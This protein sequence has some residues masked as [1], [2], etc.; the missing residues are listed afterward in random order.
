MRQ[1]LFVLLL[2]GGAAVIQGLRVVD[3]EVPSTTEA[4]AVPVP[5]AAV[6][7]NGKAGEAAA[8]LPVQNGRGT[9]EQLS[10]GVLTEVQSEN[11]NG[12][13]AA[14]DA[15][16][17]EALMSA[18][19]EDW[20]M[21]S[22]GSLKKHIG[23][24]VQKVAK[25]FRE[26]GLDDTEYGLPGKNECPMGTVRI[27]KEDLCQEAADMLGLEYKGR[28]YD[29]RPHFPKG[30]FVFDVEPAKVYFN[31]HITGKC[32]SQSKLVCD[33]PTGK[34]SVQTFPNGTRRTCRRKALPK[35]NRL[36]AFKEPPGAENLPD[37][38][39]TIR[40]RCCSRCLSYTSGVG[41]RVTAIGGAG[42]PCDSGSGC[43]KWLV[44][45]VGEEL[46]TIQHACTQRFLV[47]FAEGD[48]A[49]KLAEDGQ[50]NNRA[51]RLTRV[52]PCV[53]PSTEC[54]YQIASPDDDRLLD[55]QDP[56]CVVGSSPSVSTAYGGDRGLNPDS[57][58][59]Y[60][61]LPGLA[62]RPGQPG[63]P[64]QPGW[65][66]LPGQSGQPGQPGQPGD[67]LL[68]G[69][70]AD[71]SPSAPFQPGD[72]NDPNLTGAGDGADND[73]ANNPVN[74]GPGGNRSNDT[75]DADDSDIAA[76]QSK[77]NDLRSNN[78]SW[79]P[80][81]RNHTDYRRHRVRC[82]PP[83]P[84]FDGPPIHCTGK[85][86]HNYEAAWEGCFSTAGC[87]KICKE[88]G[89]YILGYVDDHLREGADRW[90]DRDNDR[91]DREDRWWERNDRWRGHR[92][93]DYS[94]HYSYPVER[95]GHT[96]YGYHCLEDGNPESHCG[97][98][99]NKHYDWCWTDHEGKWDY[100]VRR[101]ETSRGWT[102]RGGHGYG[103]TCSPRNHKKYSWCWTNTG[104][105][106]YCVSDHWYHDDHGDDVCL[107]AAAF[108]QLTDDSAQYSLP[109]CDD[110]SKGDAEDLGDERDASFVSALEY[111]A[112]PTDVKRLMCCSQ[113]GKCCG[114]ATAAG[115]SAGVSAAAGL[116][117]A[118]SK[119]GM[120]SLLAED[121]DGN[122]SEEI[123]MPASSL[124]D[125]GRAV[126]SDLDEDMVLA[127]VGHS[128]QNASGGS[129][130]HIRAVTKGKRGIWDKVKS[131]GKAVVT[132]L[133]P[134][135]APTPRPTPLFATPAPTRVMPSQCAARDVEHQV[136]ARLPMDSEA[137][138]WILRPTTAP[139]EEDCGRC[140]FRA[141][142]TPAPTP[143]PTRGCP[144][145]HDK[146]MQDFDRRQMEPP[147]PPTTTTTTMTLCASE[148]NSIKKL[149][150]MA[151]HPPTPCPRPP[152]PRPLPRPQAPAAPP[153]AK[154]RLPSALKNAF[155]AAFK[156]L[157]TT[158]TTTEVNIDQEMAR[159]SAGATTTKSLISKLKD[160]SDAVVPDELK[161][162]EQDRDDARKAVKAAED[163]GNKQDLERAQA[164]EAASEAAVEKA[165]NLKD[166]VQ[167]QS[168]QDPDNKQ[169]ADLSDKMQD[170][171]P[172]SLESTTVPPDGEADEVSD[173]LKAAAEQLVQAQSSQA[174]DAEE[175]TSA[176]AETTQDSASAETALD[177]SSTSS[178]ADAM[179]DSNSASDVSTSDSPVSGDVLAEAAAAGLEDPSSSQAP[180]ESLA[181]A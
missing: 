47:P 97:Q 84:N 79:Q 50:E 19:N 99:R 92:S 62:G 166:A 63:Q 18:L 40:G 9:Q 28:A 155:K 68:S 158:K 106:D 100:C 93:M 148:F 142:P 55:A 164:W 112:S 120:N 159:L 152:P 27:E 171:V 38:F 45:K 132:A 49:L 135:A 33:K 91:W 156:K 60:G 136:R 48:Y 75:I 161:S 123:Q 145:D 5:T 149:L 172:D 96:S 125:I 139:F 6:A 26:P 8:Q 167:A 117:A 86:Y 73:T 95:T 147:L 134:T 98:H 121:A 25:M 81:R 16:S 89:E 115:L 129:I 39:Y 42:V 37:N 150:A 12:L 57:P 52:S 22:I 82:P 151:E 51:W 23:K 11:G 17:E 35:L 174:V 65:P 14:V 157:L 30:C 165:Q 54:G 94:C 78:S 32:Q 74:C 140:G 72:P 102:C 130:H 178:Q 128:R 41:S 176:P 108:T 118:A 107:H 179:L 1:C 76:L 7:P 111:V 44:K 3:D 116:S 160:L 21:P 181:A 103:G 163:S 61:N 10:S 34:V 119:L 43:Q 141:L 131:V 4:A 133:M 15:E 170:G 124:L 67:P 83:P 113:F 69:Q 85:A 162:A 143:C 90:R 70:P 153:K 24:A 177:T 168:I 56:E 58:G 105:W 87:C 175:T 137:Q 126:D 110:C 59:K 66:G 146:A 138:K 88:H 80:P 122:A 180:A 46:Y 77:L 127:F 31:S 64:G 173:S 29:G 104:F 2:L 114:D 154:T 101:Q 13:S 144:D 20:S 71:F 36:P 109:E 53:G 169:L